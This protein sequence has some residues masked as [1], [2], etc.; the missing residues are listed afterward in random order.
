[1][2]R[3]LRSEIYRPQEIS[4]LHVVQ[5]CVRRAYLAGVDTHSGKDYSYRR[6]WI[7]SRIEKLASVFGVD[8]LTYAILS[9]HLHV[10]LRN[11]PDVV[12]TWSDQQIALRW[13]QIFSGRRTQE[14]LGDPIASDVDALANDPE[15]IAVLRLRLSDISWFMRAL[16]EP[17]ARLANK[18]DECTGSFWEGRFKA[19]RI[20]DEAALLACCVYVDLN[21]IRAAMAETPEASKFTGG[22]D[23]IHAAKGATIE[24]SAASMKTI[25]T[26]EAAEIIKTSTTKQLIQRRKEARNRKGPKIPKD[27][28]L[29]P[30]TLMPGQF[31][32]RDANPSSRNATN[33]FTRCSDK[34]FLQMSLEEYLQL[35]DWTG[36]KGVPKKRG[37]IPEG[38]PPILA[39]LGIVDEMW[40]DLVWNFKKYFG[41]SRG[42]GSP[43][44]MRELAAGSEKKFQPGQKRARKCF[45]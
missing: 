34:G 29:A 4:I 21:P 7:R 10:V 1:M 23:R 26:D 8:V 42:A 39:R 37:S 33:G 6:E 2:S 35:L 44:R 32:P 3:P 13:L 20:L 9:N 41:R 38:Y 24:S 22:Y 40:C 30:L 15:R 18:Q 14:Q 11:R 28:W 45:A 12:E 25:P 43:D 19:Q 27:S 31:G 16:S 36:R 17:I 5:R